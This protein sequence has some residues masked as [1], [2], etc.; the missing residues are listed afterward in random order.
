[1][2]NSSKPKILASAIGRRK[3]AVASVRLL[4]GSGQMIVNGHAVEKYFPGELA[5]RKYDLPFKLLSLT[6][7]DASIK[8]NGG[9]LYGQLD[10]TVLGLSRALSSLK[11]DFRQ[12]LSSN[13][14]LSRDSRTRQRRMIGTGG[15]SRR[16]KQS[17]KR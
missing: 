3:E 13:G 14:L 6:K 10:A 1:M 5:K 8:T 15:K 12:I 4:S 16:R 7:Y 2:Q 9:G 17:P 11:A